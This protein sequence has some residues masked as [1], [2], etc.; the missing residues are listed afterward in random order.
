MAY[1]PYN[2]GNPVPSSDARDR[3]DNSAN[4][5]IGMNGRTPA[6]FDR[7]GFRRETWF[8]MERRFNGIIEGLGWSS[9]GDYAAGIIITSHTQVV[10][11]EGQPYALKSTVPASI[12]APYVTTGDWATEGVN[13]K[14]VGDSLLRQDVAKNLPTARWYG[15]TGNGV[16]NDTSSFVALESDIKHT[17]FDLHGLS[18][19]V[20]SEPTGNRYYNGTFITPD[21][22][23]T[24][25][26]YSAVAGAARP[27]YNYGSLIRYDVQEI[28]GSTT[29]R[30]AQ[31]FAF[32][33][34]T[35]SMFITEG[36]F[37][38][39][40]NMD[41]PV[42]VFQAEPSVDGSAVLGHQGLA[43]EYLKSG[44]K[45]WSTSVQG[46]R[47]AARFSYV[48]GTPITTAEVYELF[49][50]ISFANSASCTPAV[51]F[52]GRYLIAHGIRSGTIRGVIR[53]FD[54][55]RLVAG[56]PG[57]YSDK[58]L[59]EF[60]TQGLHNAD[61]PVQG[62]ACDGSTIFAVAGGTGFTASVNK[63]L[64]T[65]TIDGQLIA[66]EENFRVGRTTAKSDGDGTRYEPEGLA[67][68]SGA[69]GQTTLMAAI[70]SGQPGQRRF[71]IYGI[72]QNIPMVASTFF[73]PGNAPSR[74]RSAI[75]SAPTAAS[76][77]EINSHV[78]GY[79]F[80]SRI[81]LHTDTCPVA[82]GEV[83]VGSGATAVVRLRN[84]NTTA[85]VVSAD[86]LIYYGGS[87]IRS[88][89]D[90]EVSLGRNINRF[91][92]VYAGT[93]TINTSDANEKTPITEFQQAHINVGLRLADE[94]GMFQWLADIDKKGRGVA[95][96]HFGT[97][98]QRAIEIFED[99]GLDPF[100]FGA[101]CLDEWE[102][103]T[104]ILE[105]A[106]LD[107]NGTV[108]REAVIQNI[109]AGRRF[110]FRDHQLQYLISAAINWRQKQ[111]LAR[112]D[113]LEKIN[114]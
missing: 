34:R 96:I 37:I 56:G 25:G 91:S 109:A 23:L 30:G 12:E 78:D 3:A 89:T 60:E 52:C 2:T 51:S 46:G 70:L 95:R 102:A 14:L 57:N 87:S 54:I 98:V 107:E 104:E 39:R 114:K 11:H 36:G 35:R 100:R 27:D 9:V 48:A 85:L 13:F 43:V 81:E 101:V 68:S 16:A 45:L 61:N 5:D 29:S 63:R 110:G 15:A 112:L 59:Y 21:S 17:D 62:L 50:N 84:G 20:D 42:A 76:M 82:A 22:R 47:F 111:I 40:Y 88:T 38:S 49:T 69:G 66:K 32:D 75:S 58:W 94:L 108:V 53:V 103:Y 71:R 19:V 55:A 67:I 106:E 24:V 93:G 72:A 105:P 44:I 41:G 99:E 64:F 65:F 18:Y 79:A 80:G 97:T 83:V 113:A 7:R 33:D 6:F 86:G 8:G 73:F 1:I 28:N 92:V 10:E 77:L 74:I 4:L 31:S 90:N 26:S